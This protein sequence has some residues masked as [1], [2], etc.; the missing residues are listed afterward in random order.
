VSAA[1]VLELIAGH[2]YEAKKPAAVGVF[3]LRVN[4][5]QIAWVGPTEVQ[6][7]SPTVK[8]GRKLPFVT[9]EAFRK[10]AGRDVTSEGTD[11]EWRTIQDLVLK[12]QFEQQGDFAALS[13]AHAWCREN[14][15]SYGSTDRTADIGLMVG[16]YV[17]AKWHNLTKR[18]QN[19]CHGRITGDAR[20]GPLT[21][22]ISR[23][24]LAK[25]EPAKAEAA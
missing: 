18:E 11:G 2:T 10:W 17:I 12:V 3:D 7:D 20:H 6:Y 14:G 16:D 8:M 21:L 13:A 15:V 5:R 25:A 24:A 1:P 22:R 23:A 9:H 19:A 4:D